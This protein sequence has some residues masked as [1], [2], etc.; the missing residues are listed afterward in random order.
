MLQYRT[1]WGPGHSWSLVMTNYPALGLF[2]VFKDQCTEA[3]YKVF[4]EN[5]ILH[6]MNLANCTDQLQALDLGVNI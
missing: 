4:D 6:I 1:L 2:G 3:V 5:K